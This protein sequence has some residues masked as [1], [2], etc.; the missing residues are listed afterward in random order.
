MTLLGDIEHVEAVLAHLHGLL[1]ALRFAADGQLVY[2]D[3][4]A[5]G[6]WGCGADAR[7]AHHHR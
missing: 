4:L 1:E 5:G 2:S 3:V 6:V 7:R